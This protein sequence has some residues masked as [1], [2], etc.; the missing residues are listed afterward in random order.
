MPRRRSTSDQNIAASLCNWAKD[1]IQQVIYFNWLDRTARPNVDVTPF[2]EYGA[3]DAITFQADVEVKLFIK[4]HPQDAHK[5]GQGYKSFAKA[6]KN[7][8]SI[9]YLH[10][11]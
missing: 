2:T 9:L 3:T 6:Q 1:T 7:L 4:F 11:L 5:E 10:S 8:P